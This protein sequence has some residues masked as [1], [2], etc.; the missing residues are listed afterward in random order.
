V[1]EG[2]RSA[3]EARG[4]TRSLLRLSAQRA[5]EDAVRTQQER[6][7]RTQDGLL[8]VRALYGVIPPGLLQNGIPIAEQVQQLGGEVIDVTRPL[9][10]MVQVDFDPSKGSSVVALRLPRTF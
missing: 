8:V 1:E 9:Q 5:Y 4:S 10:V 2:W 7:Q 6:Q 3:G